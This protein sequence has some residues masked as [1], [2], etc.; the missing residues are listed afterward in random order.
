MRKLI[1]WLP[2]CLFATLTL[3]QEEQPMRQVYALETP[4]N[5]ISVFEGVLDQGQTMPLRWAENSSVACFP[6]TRFVE[7]QGN[8][9]LYR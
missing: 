8:H 3:A 7:Y 2:L 6:G 1:L 5:Q 4:Q 9:V